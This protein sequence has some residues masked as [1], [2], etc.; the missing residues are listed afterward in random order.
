MKETQPSRVRGPFVYFITTD[1]ADGAIL[2]FGKI[3]Y[4]PQTEDEEEH[5]KNVTEITEEQY[6][7]IRAIP[8]S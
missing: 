2:T 1:P 6:L 4:P 8:N 5:L 7:R 3:R